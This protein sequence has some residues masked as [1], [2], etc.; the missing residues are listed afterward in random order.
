LL[1]T[2]LTAALALLA[3]PGCVM[4]R[5]RQQGLEIGL[6]GAEDARGQIVTAAKAMQRVAEEVGK[7]AAEERAPNIGAPA[8]EAARALQAAHD[9]VEEIG[10]TLAVM[11]QDVGRSPV[12][13]PATPAE[14]EAWRARYRAA[15]RL[16]NMAMSWVRGAIS[17]AVGRR[18]GGP[19]GPAHSDWSPA[20][21]VGLITAITAAAGA[22]GETAR[23]GVKRSRSS[24]AARRAELAE[25]LDALDEVKAKH[26]RAVKDATA[27]GK[28]PALRAAFVRREEGA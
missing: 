5:Y 4:T 1:R 25:A 20:S 14:R 6:S 21:I 27:R 22:A 16:L 12:P 9:H 3:C 15:S 2:T 8:G 18:V 24:R 13:P 10:E 11:Q 19:A 17:A 28:R 7:A 26:P 23:R